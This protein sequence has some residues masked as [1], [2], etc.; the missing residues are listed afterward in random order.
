MTK[1]YKQ[2]VGNIQQIN[3]GIADIGNP[4]VAKVGA[5]FAGDEA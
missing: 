1:P 4:P 2:L 5:K 3:G